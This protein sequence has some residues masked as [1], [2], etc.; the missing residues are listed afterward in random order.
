MSAEENL[1]LMKVLDDSWNARDWETFN[2]C[3]AEDT[4]VYWPGQKDPTHGRSNHRLES[5]EFIKSVDN[6]VDNDPYKIQFGQG[7]WTCTVARWQGK[8]VGPM[9][10]PDGRVVPPTGKTFDLE[11]CTVARWKDGQIVE[12]KLLYDQV[13]FLQQLGVL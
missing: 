8:M 5:I 10:A 7:D 9:K 3:H 4:D 11:F 1:R 6:H 13:A 2:K 12:E